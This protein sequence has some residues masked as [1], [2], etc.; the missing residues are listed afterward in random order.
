[1]DG[2]SAAANGARLVGAQ[3]ITMQ[4]LDVDGQ[5]VGEPVDLSGQDTAIEINSNHWSAWQRGPYTR[6]PSECYTEGT[7]QPPTRFPVPRQARE[8][9]ELYDRTGPFTDPA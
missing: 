8:F 9:A 1:M 4:R 2:E 3:A 5:P 6:E 7:T